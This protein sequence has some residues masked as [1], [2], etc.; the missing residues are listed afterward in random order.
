[1]S[2]FTLV[3]AVGVLSGV[4]GWALIE[5]GRM[6]WFTFDVVVMVTFF[7]ACTWWLA[8]RGWV[9]YRRVSA[10]RCTAGETLTVTLYLQRRSRWP[11][12]WLTAVDILPSELAS[13]VTS[14]PVPVL[15]GSS[16]SAC[17]TYTLRQVPRGVYHFGPVHI[18]TGD[19]LGLLRW[20]R[21]HAADDEVVVY[22][23]A[24]PVHGWAE[25]FAAAGRR[26][27]ARHWMEE[28][29]GVAGVRAY[30]PGDRIS[31]IH[32]PATARRGDLQAKVLDR[33][34]A[35]T[36]W[37]VP[38]VAVSAGEDGLETVLAVSASLLRTAWLHQWPFALA[39]TGVEWMAAAASEQQLD[40][41]LYALAKVRAGE[42]EDVRRKLDHVLHVASPGTHVLMVAPQLAPA[43]LAV[44]VA[45]A[46][47]IS[48]EWWVTAGADPPR[49]AMAAMRQ[50]GAVVYWVPSLAALSNLQPWGGEPD[51]RR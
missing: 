3:L 47:R 26:T 33:H 15:L 37:V 35:R 36:V 6:P 41:C 29:A 18:R 27:A 5:G 28:A 38:D 20:T 2:R 45:A 51:G 23:Q 49:A 24:V 25:R 42:P 32:W 4:G 39:L 10:K 19:V 43:T 48:L 16:R 1:M 30:Q 13:H 44:A 40:A 31:R 21:R 22:P 11:L 46:R 34:V 9:V 7:E 12:G 14:P 8:Q 17:L 50:A